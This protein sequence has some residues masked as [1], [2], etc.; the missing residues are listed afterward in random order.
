MDIRKKKQKNVDIEARNSNFEG[1]AWIYSGIK[2]DTKI[3]VGFTVGKRDQDTCDRFLKNIQ[4]GMELPSTTNKIEFFSDGNGQYRIGLEKIF[5]PTCYR[6]GQ[7]VK[8]MSGGRVTNI[9]RQWIVGEGRLNDVQTS[10]VENMN[11]IARG[12]QSNLVR[13]TKG[14]AKTVNR[15]EKNYELFL[16]YRNF[17]R[18][19]KNKMTPAMNEEILC[20]PLSWNDFLTTDY[21]T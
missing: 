20:K 11:G 12:C 17:F 10:Q 18:Q 21:Q 5:D 14:F 19:D 7:L 1:D 8:E 13:K 9:Y 15:V 4:D 6:Y 3:I 16:L 2:R